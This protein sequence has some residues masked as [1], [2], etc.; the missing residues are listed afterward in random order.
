MLI[1]PSETKINRDDS[2]EELHLKLALNESQILPLPD[3][4]M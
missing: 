4:E 1:F 3:L 2:G